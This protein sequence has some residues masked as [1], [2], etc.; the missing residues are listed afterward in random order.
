MRHM[1]RKFRETVAAKDIDQAQE[2]S[3]IT[4]RLLDKAAAKGV[5]HK[6]VAARLKSRMSHVIV[7]AKQAA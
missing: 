1:L 7:S 3:R 4:A 5:I 6:N 2:L